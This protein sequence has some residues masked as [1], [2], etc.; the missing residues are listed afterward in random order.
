[1]QNRWSRGIEADV[2]LT[3]WIAVSFAVSK[4]QNGDSTR[5]QR[6]IGS[7]VSTGLGRASDT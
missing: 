3:R 4:Q 1:M 5:G 6:A 2:A 7:T